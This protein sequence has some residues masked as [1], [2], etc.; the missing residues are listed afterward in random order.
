MKF[1][2]NI[3]KVSLTYKINKKDY[4][5][6]RLKKYLALYSEL[7]TDTT[8]I[9]NEEL[10]NKNYISYPIGYDI[11]STD[12]HILLM[13]EFESEYYEEIIGKLK[14]YTFRVSNKYTIYN[15]VCFNMNIFQAYIHNIILKEK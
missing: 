3:P 7:L 6:E 14:K 12:K 15:I 9:L 1:D 13:F 2:V 4:D 11:V 5:I 8:S 10:R